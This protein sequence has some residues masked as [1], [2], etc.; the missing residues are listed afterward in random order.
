MADTRGV[1]RLKT[2]RNDILN[3]EFVTPDEA[4]F[5][6]PQGFDTGYNTGGATPGAVSITDK[7]TYTTD[8]TARVPGANINT[9]DRKGLKGCGSA[10]AGYYG[11]GFP[12]SDTVNKMPYS[13]ETMATLPGTLNAARGYLS[14]CSSDLAG[15]WSGGA[16]G[17]NS[18][19]D[20]CTFS[21]DTV[22]RAPG[23]DLSVARAFVNASGNTQ[24]GFIGGG[25]LSPNYYSTM[26]KLS[27]SGD[28]VAQAP[29]ASMTDACED[30]NASA[31]GF[32]G[33]F[34]GG[35]G[36]GS[37]VHSRVDKCNFVVDT[38]ARIPGADLTQQVFKQGQTGT[39]LAGYLSGGQTPARI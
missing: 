4:F 34:A 18:S 32:F 12:A 16:P 3:G 27:F 9:G 7:T 8:T 14:A 13:T 15:Y 25:F 1:F 36:P 29:A 30:Y 10:T 2:V 28:T 37:T 39:A 19:T 38:T 22:S 5:G 21:T 6:V 24:I 35:F 33:Y 17:S 11:G 26:D 23:A 31:N 20:K